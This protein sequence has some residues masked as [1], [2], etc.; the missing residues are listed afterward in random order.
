MSRFERRT[1]GQVL[2]IAHNGNLSGGLMFDDTALDGSPL[3]ADYA[4]RRQRWEPVYEVTQVKGDGEAHPL[5]SPDDRFADFETWYE[6]DISLRPRSEDPKVARQSLAGEYARSGLKKGLRYS[7]L[8]GI[9]PYEFG[10]IGSTD[11]PHGA[12]HG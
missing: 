11:S 3:T 4:R 9:N 5:L 2:A 7:A 8:L 1:G 12:R 6:T 10:L